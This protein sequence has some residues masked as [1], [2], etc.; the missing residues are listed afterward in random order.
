[1]PPNF[2]DDGEENDDE[3]NYVGVNMQ[4]DE[5]PPYLPGMS[6][7]EKAMLEVLREERVVSNDRWQSTSLR[8][9]QGGEWSGMYELYVPSKGPSGF[10]MNKADA[11]TVHTSITA[12]DFQLEGVPLYFTEAY[13][14]QMPAPSPLLTPTAA[15][16]LLAPTRDSYVST[17]FRP[18]RGNQVVANAFTLCR[19]SDGLHLPHPPDP[20]EK[21]RW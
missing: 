1:M 6:D 21:V 16:L 18:S 9:N 12:G 7:D 19:V 2:S 4:Y 11:G 14:T 8:D 13:A 15:E 17:D 20:M 5:I 10:A 3:E